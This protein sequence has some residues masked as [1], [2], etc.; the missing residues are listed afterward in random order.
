[1]DRR[2]QINLRNL[3][4]AALDMDRSALATIVL[5]ALALGVYAMAVRPLASNALVLRD[6]VAGLEAHAAKQVADTK[7]VREA[8]PLETFQEQLPGVAQAPAIVR[9][10]HGLAQ[11]AGLTLERGEYRPLPDASARLVRYQIV[12]PVK[13][14]YAQ[15]RRFLAAAMRD[16][17]G[18]A[19]DGIG[20]H[21][22]KLAPDQL[23][24][25]L[26][27]TAFLRMPS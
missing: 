19:L 23:E 6:Q 22:D 2:H 8:S 16:M 12:L 4:R 17:P 7:P 1:M 25:Q 15:V 9:Q 3:P 11:S 5:A 27:F 13:G 26:R 10:L 20:F 14:S 24:V 18:L 21:R